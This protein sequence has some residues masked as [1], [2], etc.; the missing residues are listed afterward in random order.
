MI[1]ELLQVLHTLLACCYTSYMFNF[2]VISIPLDLVVF[3]VC[4]FCCGISVL[5]LF[6]LICLFSEIVFSFFVS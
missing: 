3:C 2:V 1:F 5:L 4:G 6:F